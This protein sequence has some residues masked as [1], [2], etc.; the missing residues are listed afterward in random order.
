MFRSV[1]IKIILIIVLLAVI[2]FAVPGVIYLNY[3]SNIDDPELIN[4]LI[5]TGKLVFI[6]LSIYFIINVKSFLLKRI[7]RRKMK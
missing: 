6:I 2:M 3:L 4:A 1:Q 7:E 5:N